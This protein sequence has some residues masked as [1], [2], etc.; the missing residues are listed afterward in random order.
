M[1]VADQGPTG[2]AVDDNIRCVVTVSF[3]DAAT[4]AKRPASAPQ[5]WWVD[6]TQTWLPQ[7]VPQQPL[8][9]SYGSI[10]VYTE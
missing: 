2:I 3:G 8:N 7:L 10:D 5:S 1:L 4:F 6:L 9:A